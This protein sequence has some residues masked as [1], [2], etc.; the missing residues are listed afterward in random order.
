MG[1]GKNI[2]CFEK[3]LQTQLLNS[4][5]CCNFSVKQYFNSL[6]EKGLLGKIFFLFLTTNPV[7]M[8]GTSWKCFA[9]ETIIELYNYL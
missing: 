7:S 4:V 3:G 9:V 8:L 1:P 6:T 2:T 5:N